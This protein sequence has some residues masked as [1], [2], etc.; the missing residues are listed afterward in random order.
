MS[1]G[2]LWQFHFLRVSFCLTYGFPDPVH[3]P[4]PHSGFLTLGSGFYLQFRNLPT[5][6]FPHSVLNLRWSFLTRSPDSPSQPR[7]CFE[8][9]ERRERKGRGERSPSHS[10][11]KAARKCSDRIAVLQNLQYLIVWLAAARFHRTKEN[12]PL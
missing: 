8:V 3:P 7:R 4:G 11:L 2:F 1:L 9:Q 6:W 12:A 10:G 5:L